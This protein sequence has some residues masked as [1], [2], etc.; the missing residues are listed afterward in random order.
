MALYRTLSTAKSA[1]GRTSHPF[2]ACLCLLGNVD[3]R[4][5]MLWQTERLHLYGLLRM[6]V[7]PACMYGSQVWGEHWS[8]AESYLACCL[9]FICIF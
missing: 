2:L 4:M 9:C 7:V 3:L 1:E 8:L 6:Y 5:N